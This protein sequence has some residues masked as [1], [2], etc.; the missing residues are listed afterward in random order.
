MTKILTRS[1]IQKNYD[2][3]EIVKAIEESYR[4]LSEGKIA[5]P[6]RTFSKTRNGGDYLYSAATNLERETFI[7]LSSPFMPW[8]A[9]KGLPIVRRVYVYTSFKDGEVLALVE[10]TDLVKYRTCAK[11]AV[12]TK[13]LA[14]KSSKILGFIGLGAQSTFHAEIISKYFQFERIVGYSRNPDNWTGNLNTIKEKT[15]IEVEVTS[16]EEVIKQ[17]DI[18]IIA[19]HSKE[20]LV[21]FEEL[22][23]GQL[24]LGLDHAE[25]VNRDVVF[26]AKTYVDYYPTAEN[27]F[28]PV[29]VAVENGFNFKKLAGDLGELVT[30]KTM[31]RENDDEIIFF[32]SLGVTNEDL[33]TVEY[34]YDKLKDNSNEISLE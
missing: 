29:K 14:K 20:P 5:I 13:Y 32:Q 17:S 34:L 1:E 21:S 8:N 33:A 12:A 9:E 3:D 24:V 6:Q 11:S 28:G 23:K 15:G 10:G 27:E 16:R 2:L 18:L 19:T 30:G 31:A 7:V 4:N 25:S 22:H 26:S